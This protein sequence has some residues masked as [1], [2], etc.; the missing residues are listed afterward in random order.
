MCIK[1]DDAINAD[2]PLH[3]LKYNLYITDRSI[4]EML[5]YLYIGNYICLVFIFLLMIQIIC[6]F[7]LENN[8]MLN[9]SLMLGIKCNNWLEYYFNKLIYF[10]REIT[11]I[12]IWL[13]VLV[14]IITLACSVCISSKLYTNLDNSVYTYNSMKDYEDVSSGIRK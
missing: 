4:E 14:L 6:R 12:Y 9:L 1:L 11:T 13:L 2:L 3:P 7:N 5:S 8:V 10:N